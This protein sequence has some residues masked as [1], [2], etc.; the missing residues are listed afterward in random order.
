ME[1]M[2]L[3]RAMVVGALSLVSAGLITMGTAMPASTSAW[4]AEESAGTE[5][6]QEQYNPRV[7]MDT[8]G[9]LI[10]L[11][12]YDDVDD[13]SYFKQ[14]STLPWNTYYAKADQRGCKSCHD[15]LYQLLQDSGYEHPSI[16]GADTEWTVQTCIDCHSAGTN[17]YFSEPE[18]FATT[19]HGLHMGL[20][21]CMNCHDTDTTSDSSSQTMYIWENVAHSKMR[22]IA[23]ISADD[24][25]GEFS[26]NQDSIDD[27]ES[28][29][30]LNEQYYD[31]DYLRMENSENGVALDQEMFDEWTIT[32]EGEVEKPTTFNLKELI[33]DPDVPKETHVMKWVCM[34][35]PQGGPGAQQ[36]EV[37]G[38]PLWWIED[39]VG[40]KD[41]AKAI[42]PSAADGFMDP[43]GVR[44]D[45]LEGNDSLIAYEI[46]G[47]PISWENGYPC[48]CV[49]GGTS[50]GSYIKELTNINYTTATDDLYD[51]PGWPSTVVA[52]T[53]H[54]YTMTGW[55]NDDYTALYNK[56]LAGFTGLKEGQ[57]VK[58]GETLHITGYADGYDEQVTGFEISMD[59][60]ESWQHFDIDN[61]DVE[62]L[63]TWEYD[64]TPT[65]DGAY[66]IQ[67]RTI[68]AQGYEGSIQTIMGCTC[69]GNPADGRASVNAGV[70]GISLSYLME[71]AGLLGGVNTVVFTSADGYEVALPLSYVK[72]RFS[73]IAY[74]IND[75][76][77]KD[78]LGS[79]NQLWLGSSSANNFA[80]D[81]TSVTFEAR[82]TPPPTPFTEEGD[83]YYGNLPNIAVEVGA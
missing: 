14:R 19:I 43:G 62:R 32:V 13:I 29:Y 54:I 16:K 1:R 45:L 6:Q 58:T 50:C 74:Q 65:E 34:I 60:G 44:L 30:S 35:N 20:A 39:Q 23:K 69:L 40:L 55:P 24:Q 68:T 46:N 57:V 9:D 70:R 66:T 71:Q 53:S 3:H 56:P 73:V 22:G 49:L 15:D 67:I 21:D 17:G 51:I 27:Q 26:W 83:A 18:G 11:A 2:S 41:T 25:T 79:N 8:E 33:D 63:V 81:V 59:Q 28:L 52:D 80:R 75:E 10:Q 7:Y 42:M 77:L 12:P 64:F 36:V 37:T 5:A 48:I 38:I 4:A 78:V 82:Q 76:P 31:W 72:Y 61:A 47:E